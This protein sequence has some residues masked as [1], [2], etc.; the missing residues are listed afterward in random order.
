VIPD[1]FPEP[2]YYSK[3]MKEIERL[4]VAGVVTET[5]DGE[6]GVKFDLADHY[7]L[8]WMHWAYKK[9]SDWTWDS[10]GLFDASCPSDNIYDCIHVDTVK[11]F[12][13]TY[14]KAVAGESISFT[15]DSTTFDAELI[16]V[17][18]TNCKLPTE[19]FLSEQWVYTDGF[20]VE[21]E[22]DQASLASWTKASKNH[23]H[24]TVDQGFKPGSRLTVS[25]KPKSSNYI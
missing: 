23:I 9:Y 10:S 20:E 7:G 12:A 6:D 16:F 24:I 25:I 8:S 2:A 22:G 18:D 19:I 5:N 14:P 15:Y 17:P 1:K 3:R 13:R 21:I 11:K 4:G